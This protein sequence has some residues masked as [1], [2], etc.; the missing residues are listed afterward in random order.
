VEED[1]YPGH[2][3]TVDMSPELRLGGGTMTHDTV[4]DNPG[5]LI[6]HRGDGPRRALVENFALQPETTPS[7]D[8]EAMLS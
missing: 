4:I 5:G 1:C 8:L 6:A 7:E 2:V 3:G